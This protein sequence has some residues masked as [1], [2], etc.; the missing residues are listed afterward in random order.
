MEIQKVVEK[1]L[2]VVNVREHENEQGDENIVILLKVNNYKVIC[3]G[4]ELVSE[5]GGIFFI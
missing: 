4:E 5:V 2:Q 1:V 3:I